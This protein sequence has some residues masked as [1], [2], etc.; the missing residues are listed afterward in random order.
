[1]PAERLSLKAFWDAVEERLAAF[2]ADELRAIVRA[3][4]QQVPPD[5]RHAFLA[6]LKPPAQKTAT[7]FKQVIRPE[8][9]LQDIKALAEQLKA[10]MKD[11]EY[12]DE[13]DYDDY[14]DHEDEASPYADFIAPLSALVERT[15]A[16]FDL[17]DFSLAR[18][19]YQKLFEVFHLEDEYGR[20][21][22]ANDLPTADVRET[23][24]RY[25]RAVYETEPLA[26]RPRVLYEQ[27][28]ATR[29]LFPPPPPM[30]NDVISITRAEPADHARFMDAWIA[31]LRKQDDS[32]AD[33][34]LREAIRLARGVE[35][36]AELAR[37]EGHKR[38]HA[39]L[40]WFTALEEQGDYERV[41]QEAQ[42]ALHVFPEKRPIRAAI[43]DHLAY[44]ARQLNASE[45]VRTA[46]W[47]AFCSA[48]SLARLLDVWETTP[49]TEQSNVMARA[50]QHL[51]AYRAHPPRSGSTLDLQDRPVTI[52][53]A[54]LA[55]AHLLA[56]EWEAAY[57]L[58]A[59][60]R[61]LGWSSPE[62]TQTIVVPFFLVLLSGKRPN[63]LPRNLKQL[64]QASLEYSSGWS[65]W[66]DQEVKPEGRLQDRL[67]RVYADYIPKI[68]LNAAQQTRFL[69]WCL[70]IANKRVDAIV[71]EQHRGSYNKAAMLI[72][73]CAEVLRARGDITQ[74]NALI[75]QVRARY[76]RH[77]AF[78]AELNAR[79]E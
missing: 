56:G 61:V 67:E 37:S 42:Q 22:D 53:A 44:A 17:G 47:E 14:Y 57:E 63:A 8:T 27:M 66:G 71:G 36:L 11:A 62:S 7:T 43:A 73:A 18:A 25:L 5:E 68:S 23:W 2:S 75:A 38:P 79:W 4:A 50:A 55:H 26:R 45:M 74:S 31:F 65:P 51:Q 6:Q 33:L 32:F 39:Y 41:M 1:M 35:G 12:Y 15:N 10:A 13:Y 49:E 48:P 20:G 78:L 40:D 21:L 64:W 9:L 77:R 29:L 58:A 59:R 19:A 69:E 3:M 34:W 28:Q 60:E 46:R 70:H 52:N 24:A 72:C 16:A 54:T 30:L 76:P